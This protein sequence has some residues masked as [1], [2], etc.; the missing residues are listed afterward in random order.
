MVSLKIPVLVATITDGEG[1]TSC[2]KNGRFW[3]QQKM[4]GNALKISSG[5]TQIAVSH[6][7]PSPL[8]PDVKDG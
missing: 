3:S 4:A 1:P 5:V 8:P 2:E 6:L 7:A